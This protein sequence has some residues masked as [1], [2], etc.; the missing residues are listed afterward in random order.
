MSQFFR[1]KPRNGETA[2]LYTLFGT[3]K[4][5]KGAT[6]VTTP[7]ETCLSNRTGFMVEVKCKCEGKDVVGFMYKDEL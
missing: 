3:H 2:I 1:V 5:P 4:V 6:V 7:T